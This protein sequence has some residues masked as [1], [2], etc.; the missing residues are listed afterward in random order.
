MA[1]EILGDLATEFE[2]RRRELAKRIHGLLKAAHKQGIGKGEDKWLRSMRITIGLIE[3]SVAV[4]LARHGVR[5]V[6]PTMEK[7]AGVEIDGLRDAKYG[8][9]KWKSTSGGDEPL[10]V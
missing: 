7:L 6:Y 9:G 2:C 8:K 1:D 3:A 5:V 10:D 4:R